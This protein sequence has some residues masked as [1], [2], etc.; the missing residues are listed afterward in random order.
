MDGH[1]RLTDLRAPHTDTVLSPRSRVGQTPLVWSESCQSALNPDENFAVRASPVRRF[2]AT[3]TVARAESM[4]I[5][6]AVSPVHPFLLVAG[7]NGDV[8]ATNPFRRVL[9]SKAPVWQQVWFNH[10]WRGPV[11]SNVVQNAASGAGTNGAASTGVQHAQPNSPSD[12]FAQPLVRI[13]EGFK[14]ETSRLLQQEGS[15]KNIEEGTVFTTI[16]EEKSAI[17]CLAWNPNMRCG[18][19]AAAGTGSGLVRVEDIALD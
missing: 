1:L 19:W 4:V 10:E 12:I 11:R 2:H 5:G 8:M 17:T 14:L 16:Y 18:G 15:S 3:Y 7:A 6:L 13:S 9:S